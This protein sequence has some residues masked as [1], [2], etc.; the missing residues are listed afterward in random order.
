MND[1]I[2]RL[3]S[4]NNN[5]NNNKTKNRKQILNGMSLLIGKFSEPDLG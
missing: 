4:N 2:E 1:T 3:S 5:Y